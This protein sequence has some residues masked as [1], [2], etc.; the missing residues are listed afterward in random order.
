MKIA[1]RAFN[2]NRRAEINR[3]T[4][5]ENEKSRLRGSRQD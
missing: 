2:S 4:K 1:R 5:V 3:R